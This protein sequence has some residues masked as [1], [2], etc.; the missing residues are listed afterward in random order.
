[1]AEDKKASPAQPASTIEVNGKP[2][3]ARATVAPG[4][5]ENVLFADGVQGISLRAGVARI[6]LYQVLAPASS[7]QPERRLVT[8][9]IAVP[10]AALGE[11]A[12]SLKA[13]DEAVRKARSSKGG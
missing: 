13:I 6:D 10:I 7:G 11:L 1:M 8:R 4:F 3:S 9:R 12:R 2:A 5:A